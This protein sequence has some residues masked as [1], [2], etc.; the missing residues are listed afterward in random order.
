MEN[1]IG[2]NV[3]DNKVTGKAKEYISRVLNVLTAGEDEWYKDDSPVLTELCEPEYSRQDIDDIRKLILQILS[4][5][6]ENTNERIVIFCYSFLIKTGN[7]SEYLEKFIDYLLEIPNPSYLRLDFILRQ[8]GGTLFRN[9]KYK[10]VDIDIKMQK[11]LERCIQTTETYIPKEL[12]DPI[13]VGQRDSNLVIVITSQYLDIEH[14]PTKSALDRCYIIKKVMD[15]NVLL[16]N[17]AELLQIAGATPFYRVHTPNYVEKNIELDHVIWKDVKI[18]FFQSEWGMPRVDMLIE[19]L[20]FVRKCKPL[21]V[22][23]IGTGS[24]LASLISRFI[25]VLSDS[26]VPSTIGYFTTQAIT[27]SKK[28]TDDD[29]TW[30]QACNIGDG[31]IIN[32]TFTMKVKP[33]TEHHTRKEVGIPQDAFCVALVGARLDS[34]LTDDFLKRLEEH[35]SDNLYYVLMGICKT[36]KEKIMRHPRLINHVKY[37]G[38]VNDTQSI[39]KLCDVYMN[40]PRTGGGF[41]V[42]EAMINGIP[43]ISLNYGDVSIAAGEDFCSDSV[44]E[45]FE[46]LNKYITDKEFYQYMSQKALKRGELLQDS[47][48]FFVENVNIFVERFVK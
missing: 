14:G 17:T 27:C 9:N 19:L 36:Y 29:L 30:M 23:E 45:M 39:L 7:D 20:K 10:N 11:L 40:P 1:L 28:I 38:F 46:C 25:P 12:L 3:L 43:P 47:E 24:I 5:S 15:K 22:L 8:I 18:P 32:G 6:L 21:Y 41:S 44:D 4:I 16:I 42:T 2:K 26:M 35:I 13:N 31:S 37:L 48:R 34:E 33:S